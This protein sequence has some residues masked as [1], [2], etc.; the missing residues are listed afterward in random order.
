MQFA[1]NPLGIMIPEDKS[2][3]T[4]LFLF[5]KMDC[6]SVFKPILLNVRSDI[7]NLFL[8][9]LV[10]GVSWGCSAVQHHSGFALSACPQSRKGFSA[11]R[12]GKV[13]P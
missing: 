4:L 5:H 6:A 12:W 8:F 7:V 9:R 11:N 2:E 10:P 3:C 13:N 1:D